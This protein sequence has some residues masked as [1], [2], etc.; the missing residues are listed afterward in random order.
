MVKDVK[1]SGNIRLFGSIKVLVCCGL[2]VAMSILLGKFLSIKIGDIFRISFENLSLIL[3]GM[4]FGPIVGLVTAAVADVVGCFLY[5]YAI[6]P[7]ITLGAA[8]IGFVSGLV[9]M[10]VFSKKMLPNIVASVLSAHIVG[11]MIIKSIGLALWYGTPLKTLLLRV[12]LYLITTV[13]EAVIIFALFNSRPFRI[14]F[15]RIRNKYE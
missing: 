13:A 2:F 12:P 10:F 7:V 5:G 11:S 3:S 15:D 9:S 6:N 8:S 1:R 4:L 14:Q